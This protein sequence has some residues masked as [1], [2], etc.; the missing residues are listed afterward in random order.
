MSVELRY[1]LDAKD[2][3]Q[4]FRVLGD[5]GA[6][7]AINKTI[8]KVVVGLRTDATRLLSDKTQVRKKAT[9]RKRIEVKRSRLN[10]LVGEVQVKAENIPLS[11]VKGV[12]MRGRKGDKHILWRGYKLRAFRLKKVRHLENDLW[13]SRSD[14]RGIRRAWS[15]TLLQE[16]KKHRAEKLLEGNTEKRFQRVFDQEISFAVSKLG[17]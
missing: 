11:G 5:K 1:E 16:Y 10:H 17:L 8:N 4:A 7:S 9:V 12:R 3:K 2:V 14:K 15:F 13:V 6:K